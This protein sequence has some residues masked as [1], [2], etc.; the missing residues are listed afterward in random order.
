MSHSRFKVSLCRQA[1]IGLTCFGLCFGAVSA[2]QAQ[3]GELEPRAVASQGQDRQDP[4]SLHEW[5]AIDQ[6]WPGT[7]KFTSLDKRVVLSPMGSPEIK[8]RYRYEIRH[9]SSNNLRA[10]KVV[11]GTLIMTSDAGPV[12]R[13]SFRIE[14]GRFL[15]LTYDSGQRPEKYQRLTPREVQAQKKLLQDQLIHGKTKPLTL[16]PGLRQH[17]R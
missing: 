2:G 15:T 4:F 10:A 13:S 16:P 3:S 1:L 17:I 12:S 14:D 6:T 8:G 11:E 9:S 5:H 7:V